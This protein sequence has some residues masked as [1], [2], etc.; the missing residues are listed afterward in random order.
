MNILT[1]ENVTKSYTE[2]KMLE[3]TSFYLQE[4]EKVGVIGSSAGG[5][6]VASFGAEKTGYAKYGLPKPAALVL[7]YPVIS[8]GQLTHAGSRQNLIGSDP[9]ADTVELLSIEKQVTSDYPPT[10]LW[11]GDAD[12]CVNPKNS[13][14]M[15]EALKNAGVLHRFMEFPG[16]GHGVGL[17]IGG[18]SE[19]WFEEAVK[20]WFS[21]EV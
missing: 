5:H 9:S 11:C 14:M 3:E 12:T 19:S 2:R 17:H 6:L 20:F 8:M 13:H 18:V 4:G 16:V 10:F 21:N 1:V 7:I 15:A